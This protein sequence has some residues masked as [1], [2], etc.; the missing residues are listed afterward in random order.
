MNMMAGQNQGL[1]SPPNVHQPPVPLQQDQ[2]PSSSAPATQHHA[3]HAPS[4]NRVDELQRLVSELLK[5]Q[6]KDK[7]MTAPRSGQPKYRLSDNLQRYC[8]THGRCNHTSDR[9][10]NKCPTHN[11]EATMDNKLGGSTWGCE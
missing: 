1:M 2:P 10:R 9:C 3:N 4:D 6:K 11:D 7:P 8:F 5:R